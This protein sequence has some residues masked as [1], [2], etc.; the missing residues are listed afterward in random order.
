MAK[1]KNECEHGAHLILTQEHTLDTSPKS[2]L[3]NS[4]HAALSTPKSM[5]SAPL[6]ST[7]TLVS[8]GV[9]SDCTFWNENG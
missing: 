4:I 2:G 9:S 5:V 3:S 1:S 6:P 7:V 8:L